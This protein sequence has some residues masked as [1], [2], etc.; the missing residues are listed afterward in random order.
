MLLGDEYSLYWVLFWHHDCACSPCY[1]PPH[2]CYR[3]VM[4]FRFQHLIV[5]RSCAAF[6]IRSVSRSGSWYACQRTVCVE[7]LHHATRK[8]YEENGGARAPLDSSFKSAPIP[9]SRHAVI[10][11]VETRILVV[12]GRL[13]K[14][15]H[16]LMLGC[17]RRG[18]SNVFIP[19]SV[20][21]KYWYILHFSW[22]FSFLP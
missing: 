21:N 13:V 19:P 12:V 8:S 1:T 9:Y 10:T 2:A 17:T 14:R 4:R 18:S 22:T 6:S 20:E 11:L 3:R 5:S 7:L 16:A 15:S